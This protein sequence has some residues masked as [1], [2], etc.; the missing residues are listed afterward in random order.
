MGAAGSINASSDPVTADTV[1]QI[2]D[3]LAKLSPDLLTIVSTAIHNNPEAISNLNKMG[4]IQE[5]EHIAIKQEEI[6]AAALT[7]PAFVAAQKSMQST[8]DDPKNVT[9]LQI[10][11]PQ[12]KD[13]KE[14]QQWLIDYHKNGDKTTHG[15]PNTWDVS[16]ITDMSELFGGFSDVGLYD[17]NENIRD[18]NV[19]N[20]T[21]MESMFRWSQAFNQP[22]DK[23]DVSN[24]TDM[25]WMFCGTEVFNQ[26]IDKWNVS[27][28]TTMAGMFCDS[29]AFNQSID[30]WDVSNVTTMED[31]F[32]GSLAFNQPLDKWNVSNVTTMQHMFRKTKV[33]NQP[34]DKWNVSDVTNMFNMFKDAE[35]EWKKN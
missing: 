10:E 31:M 8:L 30:K 32:R 20:V 27:N 15:H 25:K 13:T 29:K 17:F 23:W 4:F 35:G 33:Y 7:D 19:S 6:V 1:Q 18:W 5:A 12:P 9:V 34:I 22:I 3:C 26:P 14:L 24:V 2:V 11:V 16:L 21:N 28:V